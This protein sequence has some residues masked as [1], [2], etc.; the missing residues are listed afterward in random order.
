MLTTHTLIIAHTTLHWRVR[1]GIDCITLHVIDCITL[2]V[3]QSGR[4]FHAGYFVAYTSEEQLQRLTNSTNISLARCFPKLQPQSTSLHPTPDTRHPT[5]NL[6][7]RVHV[8]F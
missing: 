3:I 5:P 1:R 4:W 7:T 6:K 2:D 8:F